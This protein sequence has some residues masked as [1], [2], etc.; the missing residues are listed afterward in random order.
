VYIFGFVGAM[1]AQVISAFQTAIQGMLLDKFSRQ[2][3]CAMA[4]VDC[5]HCSAV[6]ARLSGT[7]MPEALHITDQSRTEVALFQ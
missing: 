4:L 2:V 1:P 6:A 3:G 5:N 7:I